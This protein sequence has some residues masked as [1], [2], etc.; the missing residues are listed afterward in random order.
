MGSWAH[1]LFW[2]PE[3]TVFEPIDT[4]STDQMNRVLILLTY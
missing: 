3:K 2:I 4:M 1:V